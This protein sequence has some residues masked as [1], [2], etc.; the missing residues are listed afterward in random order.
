M[1]ITQVPQVFASARN[2]LYTRYTPSDWANTQRQHYLTADKFRQLSESLRTDSNRLARE[3]DDQTR[4]AQDESGKK[5]GERVS[6]IEFWR[7]EPL[8]LSLFF[9]FVLSRHYTKSHNSMYTGIFCSNELNHETDAQVTETN[10]LAEAKRQVERA[11]LETENPLHIAQECL[12]TREKRQGIDL[13]HDDTERELLKVRALCASLSSL[14]RTWN[15]GGRGRAAERP[16]PNSA[17]DADIRYTMP[18]C[19]VLYSFYTEH[20]Q[21]VDVI[22]RSQDELRQAI[23]RANTQLAYALLSTCSSFGTSARDRRS[24]RVRVRVNCVRAG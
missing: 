5:L 2:A 15:V 8:L 21:E 12:F 18:S 22:K 1:P 23:D 13:V 17:F 7:C 10:Q 11:L 6:D 3:V 19:V 9:F 16:A 20:V 24:A 4:A 14:D